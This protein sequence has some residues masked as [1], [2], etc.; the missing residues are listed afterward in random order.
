MCNELIKVS[1]NENGELLVSA[2]DLHEFLQVNTKFQDWFKRMLQYG[3]EESVDYTKLEYKVHSQ[4]R[5]RTYTEVNYALKIDMA[6]EIAMIQRNEKGKQARQYFLECER[7]LKEQTPQLTHKQQLQ[8]Q[9]FS[10]DD[11]TVAMAHKELVGIEVAEATAPLIETIEEQQVVIEQKQE[12]LDEATQMANFSH[13]LTNSKGAWEG[14]KIVKALS[15][16]GMGRT[17]FYKWLKEEHIFT[18]DRLPTQQYADRGY[19]KVVATRDKGGN[20]YWVTLWTGKG[21]AYIYKK[22]VKDGY[23]ITK[24]IDEIKTE[25]GINE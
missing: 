20:L 23:I 22:L 19:F 2:R 25:L 18:K 13:L 6:K 3:F 12:Q 16:K 10:H 14:L 8:L 11:F 7:K 15:V 9:L 21:V 4:K 1:Q 24:T 17:N 5:E